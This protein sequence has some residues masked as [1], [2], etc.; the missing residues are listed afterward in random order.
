[1]KKNYDIILDGKKG[2]N[3]RTDNIQ[4]DYESATKKTKVGNTV[5]ILHPYRTKGGIWCFDDDDLDIV[6]EPFIGK[7]N[8]M[9]DMYAD[10]KEG[11]T[12]YISSSP[13]YE[14]TL[15]LSK[16]EELGE[17]MYQLD[18][19]EIVGW[20]CSCLLNYFPDYVSNI[21]VRIEK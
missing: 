15:S 16:K 2:G 1:M 12:V 4:D 20:L 17:G 13:I 19:T 7:I 6:A 10:G 11:I 14:Q 18:G 21:Y 3:R 5:N 9:I 8:E